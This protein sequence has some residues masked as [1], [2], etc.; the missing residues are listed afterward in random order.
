[1]TKNLRITKKWLRKNFACQDAYKWY[2]KQNTTDL[3][4]LVKRAKKEKKY[5]WINWV[6]TRKMTKRQCAQ[7]AIYAAEKVLHIYEKKYP[8]DSR[9]RLAIEAAKMYLRNQNNKNIYAIDAA[10]DVADAAA[11]DA[12]AADATIDAA[13]F[14]AAF[15]ASSVADAVDATASVAVADASVAIDAAYAVADA[16]DAVADAV[17]AVDSAYIASADNKLYNQIIN[18]GLRLLRKNNGGRLA[19]NAK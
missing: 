6:I 3:F 1:M 14:A 12:A 16:I 4:E 15:A 5:D 10:A 13:A 11:S 17:D 2:C 7:Y 9:P 8:D 18:Y 19:H